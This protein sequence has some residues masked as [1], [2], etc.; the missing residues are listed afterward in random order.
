MTLTAIGLVVALAFTACSGGASKT[1]APDSD[2]LKKK[3]RNE[4]T[5]IPHAVTQP[6]SRARATIRDA[7]KAQAVVMTAAGNAT[8]VSVNLRAQAVPVGYAARSRQS[9]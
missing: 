1:K 4:R 2:T 3:G 8:K 6:S 7:T 5:T 9:R